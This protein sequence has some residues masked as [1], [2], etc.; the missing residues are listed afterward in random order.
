MQ[1]KISDITREENLKYLEGKIHYET[2]LSPNEE[3]KK[4]K[5]IELMVTELIEHG[6]DENQMIHVSKI[7]KLL[8]EKL[9][10]SP[11]YC[12]KLEQAARLYDIGNLAI[13]EE[14]YFKD[15]V[16]T[17]SEF[18]IVKNHTLVGHDF[19][20]QYDFSITKLAAIISAEHH[21]WW[22]GTGYP[23]HFKETEIN[24]ASRIV[25]LADTVAALFSRRPGREPWGYAEILKYVETRKG[26][27]FDPIIVDI[28]MENKAKIFHILCKRY[29][30]FK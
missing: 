24:T 18:E 1:R 26:L 9:D 10:L 7:S 12:I 29:G 11:A 14:I 21:E 8:A 16:L 22:N 20:M 4:E 25:G 19:L 17:F 27:Q 15:E 30:D 3:Y 6:K 28:F 23:R 2:L 13:A 5:T